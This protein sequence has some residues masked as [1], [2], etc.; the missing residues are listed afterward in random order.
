MAQISRLNPWQRIPEN[1]K[2]VIKNILGILGGL[3]LILFII[4]ALIYW[5]KVQDARDEYFMDKEVIVVNID[6]TYNLANLPADV[7]S[8][9]RNIV[10][11]LDEQR[12]INLR[13]DRDR[14]L[15]Q[16]SVNQS[17]ALASQDRNNNISCEQLSE[18][19]QI[20]LYTLTGSKDDVESAL[21]AIAQATAGKDVFAEANWVIGAPWSPTGSP[22]SPTGS[23]GQDKP[24][25]ASEQDY[26][27]QW[28]FTTIGLSSAKEINQAE[29]LSQQ[30]RV[31]IF[32]TS[33][34]E[35]DGLQPISVIESVNELNVEVSH[36]PFIATPVPPKL[37]SQGDIQVANHGY[38]STSFINEIAPNS[39]I[40]LIRVLTENNRGDLATLNRE[41]LTFMT[42]A[43]EDNT[44]AVVNLSLG[45]PPLEPFQPFA[46]LLPWKFPP[47]FNLVQQLNSL[48][49]VT[50]IGECLDVVMVAAAGN[51]SAKSLKV[52]NFPANWGTVLGVT[53]SNMNN[54]QS[55]YA[56]NG[57][58]AAPG[59]D[60]RS[61]DDPEDICE[62]KLDACSSPDCPFAVI[63]YVHPETLDNGA[64]ETRQFWV[65]SSFATP[66]VSG[67]AAL[68]RQIDPNLT[69]AE[70]RQAIICGTLEPK[71]PQQVRVINVERTLACIGVDLEN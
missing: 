12:S 53:A 52:A 40:Q 65:G 29:E 22:W 24:S 54:E 44:K 14:L 17:L 31:G 42:S 56:N 70:I 46:P 60:G 36:P 34:L 64:T 51:D 68:L 62:P 28:A 37:G 38:F 9:D 25:P 55:C 11:T 61:A 6:S 71:T 63:G 43:S 33:P 13:A 35:K 41:L 58:I 7:S 66:M 59:G 69:A 30:V 39:E 32:D 45:I 23:A 50:Q 57:D 16:K 27:E 4:A 15:I 47:P 26:S 8:K 49:I 18:L 10:L 48:Q 20:N 5:N 67:L 3:I 2:S 21:S 1:T 19:L